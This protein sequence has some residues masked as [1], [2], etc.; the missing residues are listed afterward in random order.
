M[1]FMLNQISS[2]GPVSRTSQ[3]G[4]IFRDWRWW[5]L[6]LVAAALPV[7]AAGFAGFDA[8]P[9]IQSAFL[10]PARVAVDGQA[11]LFVTDPLAGKVT[12]LDAAGQEVLA[13]TGMGQPLGLAVATDGK[14]FL[15]DAKTGAVNI[16]DPQWNPLGR[17]GRGAGEFQLPVYVA[18]F[19]ENG[20]TTVYV[21][22]GLAHQIRAYREGVLTGQYG[23]RGIGLQHFDFPAGICV[24]TNG[25]LYVVDQNN[26]RVQVLDRHGVFLRWFTLQ[27]SPA[28]YFAS[29]RAQGIAAD[30]RGWLYVA[31]TFQGHVKVFDLT[32]KFLGY[33]GS[34]GDGVG[35][36]RSPG[37]VTV[38]RTGR[39][40]VA[41]ANNGRTDGFVALA[42]PPLLL[43]NRTPAGDVVVTWS[44]PYYSLQ[45]AVDLNGPW[46]TLSVSSPFTVSAG[47]V[48][49]GKK[50]L[51]RLV[52]QR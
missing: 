52:R 22:D 36:L 3:G 16:F 42:S 27:P 28:Q 8:L 12:V 34:Y 10:A 40:W 29:G 45:V 39:L 48:N 19:T 38:D 46:N 7:G 35:Q 13:K 43:L 23:S 33:I 9:P 37:G 31:D 21:S 17:L 5:G 50:L 41:N 49:L 2:T 51:F 15:G 20:V 18:T 6:L 1:R 25:L 4:R 26:D 32:G 44:E 30:R 14:I 11:R 24:A 47:S